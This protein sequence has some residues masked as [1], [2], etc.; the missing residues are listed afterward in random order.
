[1]LNNSVNNNSIKRVNIGRA[2]EQC[3]HTTILDVSAQELVVMDILK[4]CHVS[5]TPSTEF[6]ATCRGA[7]FTVDILQFRKFCHK[8]PFTSSSQAAYQ[9]G[10]GHPPLLGLIL[11]SLPDV[12]GPPARSD[13][14]SAWLP[15]ATLRLLREL[16]EESST[17]H[18][19]Q[20]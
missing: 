20:T 3:N 14:Y 11:L 5:V 9:T 18:L 6:D 7:A 2:E 12:R 19:S 8:P 17:A 13:F 16:N 4:L 15:A 10:A 1:M